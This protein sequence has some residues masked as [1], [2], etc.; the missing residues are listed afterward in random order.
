M[1]ASQKQGWRLRVAKLN[2]WIGWEEGETYRLHQ[3]KNSGQPRRKKI[4]SQR[5]IFRRRRL[6]FFDR[7]ET[8]RVLFWERDKRRTSELIC[9]PI[10]VSNRIWH[11]DWRPWKKDSNWKQINPDWRSSIRW[12]EG[13][14]RAEINRSWRSVFFQDRLRKIIDAETKIKEIKNQPVLD[15][16]RNEPN[17]GFQK[18]RYC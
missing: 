12:L 3:E 11:I 2:R 14:N 6:K 5:L 16:D 13:K 10:H 1:Q 7:W 18:G 8:G 9:L 4:Y 15:D 17:N